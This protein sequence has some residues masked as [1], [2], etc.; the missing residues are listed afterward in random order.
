MLTTLSVGVAT[1]SL[2]AGAF[3]SVSSANADLLLRLWN[4]SAYRLQ[5][6]T[7]R[8]R[9][10]QRSFCSY[11]WVQNK[12]AIHTE[13]QA[14]LSQA[15]LVLRARVTLCTRR[16]APQDSPS[17]SPLPTPDPKTLRG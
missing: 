10:W 15:G 17:V 5:V 9:C 7:P 16:F 4:G 12:A 14:A 13:G 2:Q 8:S 3:Q 1:R 11:L 6:L